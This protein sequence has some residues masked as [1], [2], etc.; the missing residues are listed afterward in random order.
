M[1]VFAEPKARAFH[2]AADSEQVDSRLLMP[3]SS[4]NPYDSPQGI[5]DETKS[6]WE[7][8]LA[9]FRPKPEAADL[10]SLARFLAGE[11]AIHYGVVF[12]VDPTD[13]Q[14]LFA[15]LPLAAV[16]DEGQV[17]HHVAEAVRVLHVVLQR[18]PQL[19]PVLLG[20][21]LVVSFIDQYGKSAIELGRQVVPSTWWEEE[22]DGLL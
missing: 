12:R 10:P 21:V 20:R 2:A 14:S 17:R 11:P 19:K 1:A 8:L 4:P 13:R 15:A 5:E 7:S 22:P 16:N 9:V 18:H 6:W 3:T